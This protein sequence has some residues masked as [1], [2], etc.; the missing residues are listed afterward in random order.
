MAETSVLF[1]VCVDAIRILND[2]KSI[3]KQIID[4]CSCIQLKII[5]CYNFEREIRVKRHIIFMK[6]TI[7]ADI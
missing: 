1:D 3:I 7:E 6:S 2:Q 5:K 4:I